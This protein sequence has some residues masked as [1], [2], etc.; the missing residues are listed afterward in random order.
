M[1]ELILIATL[2]AGT[3]NI[4]V[5]IGIEDI[6]PVGDYE[7]PLPPCYWTKS[8]RGPDDYYQPREIRPAPYDPRAPRREPY[9]G[10]GPPP[11]HEE[12]WRGPPPYPS[13][14]RGR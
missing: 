1:I 4:Q 12:P 5:Q 3:E 9:R 14:Y 8:C 13:P 6:Q 11:V 10:Y 7:W 2:I